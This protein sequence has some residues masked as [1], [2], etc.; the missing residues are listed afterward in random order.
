MSLIITVHVREG[1]VMASDSRL[2]LNN[3][4]QSGPNQTIHLSVSQSDSTYKTFKTEAGVG[5]STAGAADISGI[6]IGGYIESFIND[7]VNPN[8]LEVDKV[9]EELLK[10]FVALN[11]KLQTIFHVAGYRKENQKFVQ[12]VW[13]VT[14]ALNRNQRM[15]INDQGAVWDGE[16]DILVRLIQPL[17]QLNPQ[18]QIQQVLPISPIQ[19]SFFTL[20]DAIDFAVFAIKSTIEALRFQTRPKTVGG[21]IDVLVI[22]PS[23]TTWIQRKELKVVL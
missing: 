21:A 18:G 15:N 17:A 11:P 9:A 7:V 19:W 13:K 4:Q 2:S 1:I 20:Q 16:S 23:S 22:K 14:V 3:Q 6:P 12:H 8:K 5:I 10:Y